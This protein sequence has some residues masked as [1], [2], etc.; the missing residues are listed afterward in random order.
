MRASSQASL[1][2][3]SHLGQ[4]SKPTAGKAVE[5]FKK[6]GKK[7]TFPLQDLF[8]NAGCLSLLGELVC[9]EL[10]PCKGLNGDSAGKSCQKRVQNWKDKNQEGKL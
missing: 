6:E 5:N 8:L 9:Q 1:L 10:L 3:N 2:R 7:K 4:E